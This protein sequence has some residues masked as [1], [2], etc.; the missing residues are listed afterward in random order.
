MKIVVVSDNH[1]NEKSL[2]DI[3]QMHPDASYFIHCGDALVS[4]S[5]LDGYIV[6]NG[7]NDY[8]L[9]FPYERILEIDSL[10]IL[11][12]HG[13]FFISYFGKK[14][15]IE[16]AKKLNCDLVL[17]GHTHLFDH[18]IEE[19]IHFINPGSLVRNRDGSAPSYAIIELNNTTL[20]VDR[21]D[22]IS[23]CNVL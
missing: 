5:A 23:S 17:Y 22:Y 15:L 16:H 3:K 20:S 13:H 4:E 21:K 14:K 18:S 2:K 8:E 19:G 9:S 6:V 12:T 1:G 10:K 11:V 7:N